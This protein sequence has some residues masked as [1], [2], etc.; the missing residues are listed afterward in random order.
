MKIIKENTRLTNDSNCTGDFIVDIY[1]SSLPFG[2]FQ[3]FCLF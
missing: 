3:R 1:S 2:S